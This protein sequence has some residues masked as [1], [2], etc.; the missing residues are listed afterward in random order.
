VNRILRL[1]LLLVTLVALAG[2]GDD[3]G[4][5]ARAKALLRDAFGRSIGSALVSVDLEADLN[6]N[7]QLDQPVRV[8]VGGPYRSN[9][10][11]KLPDTDW[12]IGISG[13]GQTFTFGLLTTA[14]KAFLDF[15]GT[16][17]ALGEKTVRAIE[18]PPGTKPKES[19]TKRLG[20]DL[21][22]WV[23][24]AK[25]A[26]DADVA[27]VPTRHVEAGLDVGKVLRGLNTI[28]G[29][30]A[31]AAPQA[32]RAQL[33][34]DQIDAVRRYVDDPRLDV[35]VGKTD[36][37]I[38]RLSVDLEFEV[39]EDARAKVGGLEGG[40]VELDVELAQ[41][42]QPQKVEEPDDARPIS[43]LTKQL[44]SLGVLGTLFGGKAPG[45]PT[46]GAGP[47]GTPPTSDQFQRYA[48]CLDAAKPDDRAAIDRCADLLR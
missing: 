10:D 22:G 13:G 47:T 45:G 28:A 30:A 35:Y 6:G 37:K 20:V 23:N 3:E 14:G 31:G 39:P 2:C 33:T 17:Y 5:Q 34:D 48:D 29:R 19:L 44:G 24:D 46:G 38:R 8:K 36:G 9:G 7:R 16:S 25:I 26:G 42:G 18:R 4:D 1:T 41:V 12:D 15:Q 27:G 43:E 11:G 32:A 40:T 21:L